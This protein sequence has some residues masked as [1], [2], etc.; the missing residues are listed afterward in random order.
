MQSGK[1]TTVQSV[2]DLYAVRLA[3]LAED[4]RTVSGGGVPS[5]IKSAAIFF[6]KENW[7]GTVDGVSLTIAKTE[8]KRENENFGY[9][10][11]ELV[12]GLYRGGTEPAAFTCVVCNADGSITLTAD[13]AYSGKIVFFGI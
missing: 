8:H 11:Y 10:V 9:T 1:A 12:D 4:I 13:E 5:V 6:Q 3:E 7:V 2:L